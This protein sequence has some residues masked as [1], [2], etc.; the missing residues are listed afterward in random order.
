[1]SAPG[2]QAI[3]IT[4]FR[5][6]RGTTVI[7]LESPIVLIHGENGAGKTSILTALELA[8]TGKIDRLSPEDVPGL[9]H[10]GQPTAQL[11]LSTSAGSHRMTIEK[12]GITGHP[13]LDSLD[14]RFFSDRC[15]LPQAVLGRLLEVYAEPRMAGDSPLTTF[16]NELLGLDELETLLAGLHEVRDKRRVKQLVPEHENLERLIQIRKD[17]VATLSSALRE[18]QGTCD[19]HLTVLKELVS[20]MDGPTDLIEDREALDGWLTEAENLAE[21]DRA[22]LAETR[23]DGGALQS[24]AADVEQQG[25]Q[26]ALAEHELAAERAREAAELWRSTVGTDLEHVLEAARAILPGIPAAAGA[27]DPEELRAT[28]QQ[29]VADELARVAGTLA[30]S[31]E[32]SATADRL[33]VVAT[34]AEARLRAIDEQL[35]G[36]DPAAVGD[37]LASLLTA[38]IPHVHGDTCPVCDRD[39]S[40]VSSEPLSTHL[41][42]RIAAAGAAAERLRDLSGARL[43]ALKEI[44]ANRA[45]RAEASRRQLDDAVREELESRRHRLDQ[46][47]EALDGLFDA[48]AGGAELMRTETETTRSLLQTRERQYGAVELRAAVEELTDRSDRAGPDLAT[49]LTVFLEELLGDTE[50]E[51][52]VVDDRLRRAREIR[53]TL[54]TLTEADADLTRLQAELGEVDAARLRAADAETEFENARTR[55]RALNLSAER[56]RAAIVREVFSRSLNAVWANLFGRLAPEEPFVPAFRVPETGHG[57]RVVATLETIHRDG[58][59]GGPPESVL[60]AGNL[61]TAALTLFLSLHLSV[62]P[63]LPWILL[64]DPVQSMDEIHVSQFAAVLRTLARQNHRRVIIALHERQLFE[65][66]AFEL[67]PATPDEDVAIVKLIRRPDGTTTT[68]VEHLAY[69]PD[70]ALAPS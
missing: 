3:S 15:Y 12:N 19:R 62:E 27:R 56:A 24:R 29:L 5:T 63:R 14:A 50:A 70:R 8:L 30:A 21:A 61:N 54:Q 45:S 13:V 41:A 22:R 36:G 18:Q 28:A 67:S 1:M 10:R 40:E 68:E 16:V 42:S 11:D 31:S 2:L 9:V 57:R 35:A 69:V 25:T 38:L 55:L 60:S 66:L 23:R 32:A 33:D 59:P 17:R 65:Y 37:D 44:D 34:E 64:D 47:I 52:A 39:F 46:S 49:P 26:P 20:A 51:L 7:P 6:L 48:V 53:R 58:E 4:D 43:A